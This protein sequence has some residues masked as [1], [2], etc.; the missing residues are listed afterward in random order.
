VEPTPENAVR[1]LAALEEFGFGGIG[2]QA[3]DFE[4]PGRIVQL[5]A[6][7]N[8]VDLITSIDGV[9]FEEAWASK[10]EGRIG[11]QPAWFIGREAL[12][13]N[14]RAAARPQVLAD[15]DLLERF[16]SER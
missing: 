6:P 4:R 13:R 12:I 9:S 5:G 10:V 8:R 7:P 14:K 1:V 3:T 15:L 11:N 16:R 2:I